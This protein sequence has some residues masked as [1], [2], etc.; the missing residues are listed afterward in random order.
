MDATMDGLC[1]VLEEAEGTLESNMLFDSVG[2]AQISRN[3]G[4]LDSG[5]AGFLCFGAFE[6]ARTIAKPRNPRTQ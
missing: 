3:P 4:S 5:G 1:H 2:G 6:G